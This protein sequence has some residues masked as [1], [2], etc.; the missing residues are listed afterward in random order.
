MWGSV[1]GA[2]AGPVIGGLLGSNAAQGAANTQANSANQANQ[3]QSQM[4]NQTSQNLAPWLGGG[5]ASLMALQ[6]ALGIPGYNADAAI[7]G[8]QGESMFGVGSLL[9]PFGLEDFKESPAY[10]FNL[11]QGM[12]AID[13]ASAARGKYYAPA[14][15]Q[16]VGK[17]SQGLASNE[18]QNAFNNYNTSQ[19]NAYNRLFGQSGA[20]QNAAVQQGGFGAAAGNAMAGNI[21]G[22]GNAQA[23]G[24]IGSANAISGGIGGAYNNYL[25]QQILGRSQNSSIP[26]GGYGG[27]GGGQEMGY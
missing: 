21:I 7:A 10:Q 12:K 22:A 25:M 8:P 18:F 20:G 2:V 26:D 27:G 24:Q 1:L 19:G 14:T 17:Y 15:L 3:L 16:D 5:Q 23:A 13:K 6:R 11:D 9:K 4:F